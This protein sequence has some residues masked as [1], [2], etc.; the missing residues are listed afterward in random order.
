MIFHEVYD[1]AVTGE[2]FK[3][4]LIELKAATVSAGIENPI[5][6]LDN[7]CIHHYCGLQETINQ[8]NLN[9]CPSVF[10]FSKS[11]RKHFFSVEKFSYLR[12]SPL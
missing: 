3:Q 4:C 6:I 12:R 2:D 7:A 10:S 9:I 5:Y 11:Y 8:L 1:K